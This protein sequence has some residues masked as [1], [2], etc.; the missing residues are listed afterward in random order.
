MPSCRLPY[1]CFVSL[2]YQWVA[3]RPPGLL[4]GGKKDKGHLDEGINIEESEMCNSAISALAAY[5]RI[6]WGTLKPGNALT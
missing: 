3:F 1:Q 2:Y 5:P 4:D 6:T